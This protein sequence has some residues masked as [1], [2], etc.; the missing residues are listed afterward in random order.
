MPTGTR[1]SIIAN[2]LTNPMTATAS[3]LIAAYS[4]TL[5]LGSCNSSG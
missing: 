2:R 4:A 3:L 5:I 1:N